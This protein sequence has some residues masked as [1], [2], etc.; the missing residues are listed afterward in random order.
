MDQCNEAC[1]SRGFGYANFGFK[2][3]GGS[4]TCSEECLDYETSNQNTQAWA[5]DPVRRQTVSV[6]VETTSTYALKLPLCFVGPITRYLSIAHLYITNIV[7][8]MQARC[9]GTLPTLRLQGPKRAV[10]GRTAALTLTFTPAAHSPYASAFK[11]S[12]SAAGSAVIAG[13][14]NHTS[15]KT[16]GQTT[17]W[18]VSFTAP[19]GAEIVSA[20][21]ASRTIK[22]AY[23]GRTVVWRNVPLVEGTKQQGKIT[24]RVR[25]NIGTA[26]PAEFKALATSMSDLYNVYSTPYPLVV[27]KRRFLMYMGQV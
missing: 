24:M 22:P 8:T 13:R 25:V 5:L 1:E 26:N 7:P 23:D 19:P 12:A 20:S 15:T 10:S 17:Q 21:A 9:P 16:Q 3:A 6:C 18:T 2:E 14:K 11:G 4:C 27:S